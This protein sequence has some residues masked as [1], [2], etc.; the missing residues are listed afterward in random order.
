MNTHTD[1]RETRTHRDLFVTCRCGQDLD[2]H[3]GSHCPRCG[4]S[5]R[6]A[7]VLVLAA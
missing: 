1:T 3:H 2:A 4:K 6:N 5:R 7:F